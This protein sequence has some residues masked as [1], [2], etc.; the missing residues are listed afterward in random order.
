MLKLPPNA[1]SG[2][3]G[4]D[5]RAKVL[6]VRETV[7]VSACPGSGKTT[8]LVAKLAILAKKWQERTRGIC[9]LSH[10]N[11][12]RDTIQSALADSSIGRTLMGYP[13]HVGTIHGFV[14][15]FLA[16][17]WMRRYGLPIKLIDNDVCEERRWHQIPWKTQQYLTNK[18]IGCDDLQIANPTF[19]VVALG[20]KQLPFG[21]HT[22]TAKALTAAFRKVAHDGY[23]CF[24][25]LF[26]W[27][28][29]MMTACPYVIPALRDRFPLVFIDESQDTSQVQS[30]L[31]HQI[32]MVGK[33]P[34]IRQRFG[35]PNQAI[36]DSVEGIAPTEDI[37]PSGSTI[38]LPNSHRF[39]QSIA[40]FADPFALVPHGLIGHGPNA[41]RVTGTVA[42]NHTIFLFDKNSVAEVLPAYAKLLLRTFSADQ[43]K[44]GRFTAIGQVHR[45]PIST[46]QAKHP[47]HVG[48]YWS[49]YAHE[50]TSQNPRARTLWQFFA[51]A[52]AIQSA[53]SDLAMAVE[54]IAESILRF[55]ML[56]GAQPPTIRRR[57][58]L[59]LQLLNDDVTLRSEY[60]GVMERLLL[61]GQM[62]SQNDWRSDW[63]KPMARAAKAIAGAGAVVT[64]DAKAFVKWE[65]AP[66]SAIVI[67]AGKR[68]NLFSYP[69]DSP[70]VSIYAGSIHSV[71]G[72]THTA[73]L[74]LET[75]WR[76]TKHRHNMELLLPWLTRK[77]KGVGSEKT[78]QQC[79]L[80]IQY[81]AMTRPTHLLCL[82]LKK[83][84]LN[85]SEID[86]LKS[87]GWK[88]E[89][90]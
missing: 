25:D 7:D 21:A 39:G 57:H 52:K 82:A 87:L 4:N 26:M 85:M 8:V 69:S 32:F 73:T 63:V 53:S 36:F 71:K 14:S 54:Q 42:E 79:R 31:L 77:S 58:Q 18:R 33:H 29:E 34:V 86:Q 28:R 17:P 80:R 2:A 84:C 15:E 22:D 38:E 3:D 49:E 76:G 20:G 56:L 72:Q 89:S 48:H 75:F 66:A 47:H 35:D 6:G 62:P 5:P 60:L 83:S 46:D 16:V 9:I 74:V 45:P 40:T 44:D 81:V 67:S 1:F 88:V 51:L 11:V 65:E 64:D 78:Y 43:L 12:A 30:D 27:A 70:Q 23:H 55:A 19:S 59:V 13:H 61:N 37:F 41:H 24:D 90:L 68:S 50:L 10:T